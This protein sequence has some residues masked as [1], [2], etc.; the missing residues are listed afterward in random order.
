MKHLLKQEIGG[1]MRK[2][3]KALGFT[4]LK[5]VSYFDIGR[6]NY[7]RIEKGEIF[8]RP[9]ILNTLRSRFNVSLDWLVTETGDMF[10]SDTGDDSGD[11]KDTV[12]LGDYPGEMKDLLLHM[13]R[14]PMVKHA[15]LGFF[16]EYKVRNKKFI[17]PLMEVDSERNNHS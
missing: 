17:D 10:V 1:R 7:S 15:V 4:Q 8:P 16:I 9:E 12:S 11:Q 2:V 14:V 3:R 13:S 6:A 5:M